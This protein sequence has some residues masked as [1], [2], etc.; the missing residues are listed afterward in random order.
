MKNQQK[1][2]VLAIVAVLLWS[3]VSTAFEL[4]LKQ[5]DF[6]QLLFIAT[7]TSVV[8]TFVF[9]VLGGKIHLIKKNSPK[10]LLKSALIALLNPFGYYLVLLKAYSILPAQIA[11]PLNYTWPVVLVLLSAPLLKQKLSAKVIIASITS[12]AGIIV[13]STQGKINELTIDSPLGIFLAVFSSVFW[14]FYWLLNVK[15]K[16]D[17]V[18]KLFLTF[19]FALIYITVVVFFFSDFNFVIGQSFYS[20]IYV[21]FFEMGI[22]FI[23]W[24]NALKNTEST[25]KIS[26]LIFLS[27]VMALFFIHFILEE[28]IFYT[29][30]IGLFLILSGIYIVNK[31]KRIN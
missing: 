18:V 13:I 14:A 19:A 22:T 31:K 17:E 11:Q 7:A 25:G 12:F 26:N 23:V 4:S 3:T 29:T 5:L 10:D 9:I 20:A 15:D 27:P 21:G 1:A 16:R 24:L 28:K 6:M 2:Y 30:Y 8:I